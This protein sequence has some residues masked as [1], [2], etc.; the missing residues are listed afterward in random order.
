FATPQGV[1]ISAYL[2]GSSDQIVERHAL[3]QS[4]PGLMSIRVLFPSPGNWKLRLFAGH[5]DTK[6]LEWASDLGFKA[7]EGS[8]DVF[9]Q[10]FTPYFD[11]GCSV[12]TPVTGPLVPNRPIE[13]RLSLPGYTVAFIQAS[14]RRIDLVKDPGSSMFSTTATF[15]P[16][17]SATVFAGNAKSGSFEGI[18]KYDVGT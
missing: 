4:S 13:F 16:G 6:R 17:G 9:P 14:G 2:V 12:Q 7:T 1:R 11:R 3:T 10:T 8:N 15:P 5:S 18:L